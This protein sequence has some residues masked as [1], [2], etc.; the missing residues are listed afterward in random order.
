VITHFVPPAIML[1]PTLYSYMLDP[2]V[3]WSTRVS[4]G[5]GGLMSVVF[6]HSRC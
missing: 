4:L 6:F 3:H 1:S 5:S 2:V